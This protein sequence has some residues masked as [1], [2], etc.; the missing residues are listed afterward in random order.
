MD[1]FW[2]PGCDKRIDTDLSESDL[3]CSVECKI[4]DA[5][6]ETHSSSSSNNT[7]T[8]TNGVPELALGKLRELKR[9]KSLRQQHR[10]SY[11][12]IPLYRRRPVVSRR[13]AVTASSAATAQGLLCRKPAAAAAATAFPQQHQLYGLLA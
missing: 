3:Y 9:S 8:T 11:P 7:S 2:C 4:K 1:T 10:P 6:P 13:A 12:W 5:N